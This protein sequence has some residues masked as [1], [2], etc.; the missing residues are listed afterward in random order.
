MKLIEILTPEAQ[1]QIILELLFEQYDNVVLSISENDDCENYIPTH[2]YNKE[3]EKMYL[4]TMKSA[5]EV[6]IEWNVGDYWQDKYLTF[7]ETK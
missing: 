5:I 3:I 6:V 2:S 1:D 4:Q 7:K